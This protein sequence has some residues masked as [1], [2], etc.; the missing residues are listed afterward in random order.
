MLDKGGSSYRDDVMHAIFK[1]RSQFREVGIFDIV[2]N[3]A[4]IPQDY[5]LKMLAAPSDP[6]AARVT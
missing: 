2:E 5:L 3:P 4:F 1:R 6:S